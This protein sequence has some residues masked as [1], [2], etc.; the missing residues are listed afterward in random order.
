M[1][2]RNGPLAGSRVDY[3]GVPLHEE[4]LAPTWHEQLARWLEE[5][6]AAQVAEPTAMV[7]ATADREG[8]PSSRAVLCKQIDPRGLVFCTN[9]TSAKGHDLFATR[10]ASATFPW[11]ALHRQAHVRGAAERL[12]ADET[13]RLW[14]A[15]P[16]EAQ[17]GAW[18]ST[19]SRVVASR[20][21][22]D[23]AYEATRRRFADRENVPVP[24]HWGGVLIR[25]DT[26][27]FWQGRASR[28]H[29][30]LRY[31]IDADRRWRVERLAP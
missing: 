6:V 18:A 15:R 23:Q 17:I 20:A 13:A 4:D 8:L 12:P 25:P 2:L 24:P 5:A 19:Q 11:I 22:L 1:V 27:E 9:Y 29:D 30:R 16:R 28:M 3:A 10:Y 14:A 21:A 7:L 26:V 31:R